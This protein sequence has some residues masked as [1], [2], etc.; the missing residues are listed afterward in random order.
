MPHR[1]RAALAV[2]RAPGDAHLEPGRL[3]AGEEERSAVEEDLDP[4][5]RPEQLEALE[6][7][8]P[9]DPLLAAEAAQR[10]GEAHAHRMRG[11][12][13]DVLEHEE[14]QAVLELDFED[15]VRLG[16]LRGGAGH[17][18][19][20]DPQRR[21]CKPDLSSTIRRYERSSP[22]RAMRPA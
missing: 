18:L 19:S 15:H 14:Q 4:S 7:P 8:Q 1:A 5:L 12:E 17:A 9:V 20:L 13:A 22:A 2:V 10:L 11:P 16:V 6:D 21:A 3:A